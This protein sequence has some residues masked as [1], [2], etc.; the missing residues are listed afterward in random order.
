M[1][2]FW[3]AGLKEEC[4]SFFGHTLP[5]M[6]VFLGLGVLCIEGTLYNKNKDYMSSDE[7]EKAT[8]VITEN[9]ICETSDSKANTVYIYTIYYEFEVNGICYSGK[10]ESQNY[11]V[12]CNWKKGNKI[13]IYYNCSNPSINNTISKQDIISNTLFGVRLGAFL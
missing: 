6:L 9:Y 12:T 1:N 13:Q 8:A 4:F 2:K 7:L 3:S 5:L 11:D 10:A